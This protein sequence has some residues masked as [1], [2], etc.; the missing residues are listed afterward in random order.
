MEI[1]KIHSY[2][3]HAEKGLSTHTPIKG[4][5]VGKDGNIYKLLKKIF[6]DAPCSIR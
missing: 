5:E 3:V 2:L 4:T 1:F 6:D